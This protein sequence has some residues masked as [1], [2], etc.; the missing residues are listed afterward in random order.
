[1]ESTPKRRANKKYLTPKGKTLAW[2]TN[3]HRRL[4]QGSRGWIGGTV[5]QVA[6]KGYGF[7]IRP[8]KILLLTTTGRKSGLR[9]T[10]PL[11][12]F[13][14]DG[15]TFLVASFAGGPKHPAWYHNLKA[16]PAVSIRQGRE[17]FEARAVVMEGD[18]RDRYWDR[19]V[20]DWPRY[21]VYQ[22]ITERTI[23][24]IELLR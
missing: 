21:G 20:G 19:L 18:E 8:M 14:F 24:L 7:P 5:F 15:R 12:Y 2:I 6:E 17:Q 9:R 16:T 10:A 23:P 22:A 1:M 13:A 3:V 4:Y 11:P